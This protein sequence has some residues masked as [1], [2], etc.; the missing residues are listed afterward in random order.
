MIYCRVLFPAPFPALVVFKKTLL[1]KPSSVRRSQN[2][3]VCLEGTQGGK[4][5]LIAAAIEAKSKS[6]GSV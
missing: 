3:F 4:R 2:A 6:N 1:I 5:R